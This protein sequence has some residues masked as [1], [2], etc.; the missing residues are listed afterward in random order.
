MTW[1][2]IDGTNRKATQW[3]SLTG[4]FRISHY[5][6]GSYILFR[7]HAGDTEETVIDM[8]DWLL[9]AQNAAEAANRLTLAPGH[10]PRHTAGT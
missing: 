6:G 8:F 10:A 2:R 9:D 1:R 3:A 4:G 7:L 5:Q